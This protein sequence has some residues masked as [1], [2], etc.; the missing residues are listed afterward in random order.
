MLLS[1]APINPSSRKKQLS[2]KRQIIAYGIEPIN[3]IEAFSVSY[4]ENILLET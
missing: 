2:R 3:K 4:T 1:A